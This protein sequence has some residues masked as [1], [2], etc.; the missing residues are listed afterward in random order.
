M[1]VDLF[2]DLGN[3]LANVTSPYEATSSVRSWVGTSSLPACV[4]IAVKGCLLSSDVI[5]YLKCN[6]FSESI[7]HFVI[8]VALWS[9]LLCVDRSSQWLLILAAWIRITLWSAVLEF[10]WL[11][12]PFYFLHRGG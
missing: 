11:F 2:A 1:A 4:Y 7:G 12:V 5:G 6:E 3:W 10:D 9:V 8:S